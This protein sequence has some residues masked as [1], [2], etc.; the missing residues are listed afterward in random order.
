M[1]TF[2]NAKINIGLNI[3]EKRADGFH[4]IQSVFYPVGLRD[5]L[6]VIE[7]T[8]T[9]ISDKITFSFSG[10]EIPG[11]AADNLCAFA[12]HLLSQDYNL[13]PIKAHLHKH[14]PI[15]A[16]L[17][18]GSAD[19]A[20]FIRLLNDKFELGLA[21]GEMHHYARQLGSD[22]SFF[23][24]NKPAFAEGKG[25]VYESIKL[26]LSNYYI[27]LVYPNIHINTAKAYSGTQPKVPSR[28]LENDILN[29]PI[30]QW[31]ATIHNDFEDSVFL[32]FP[33]IQ[34]IK[35]QLYALG[36][37][38]AAMSGSG[39]TVYGIFKNLPNIQ[40]NFSNCFVWEGKL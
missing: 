40:N 30:E 2:P 11:D 16:G 5:A 37:I 32:Q 1:I 27:A 17:G 24:S 13:P 9:L 21:W 26:D 39:S 4:N 35:E 14:I 3:T 20:F 6:E 36:A 33:E 38:Y 23:V 8:D 34:K 25:D 18:G 10:I 31:K 22:C 12:Y 29:L 15:G 28:S 19:A 7:N